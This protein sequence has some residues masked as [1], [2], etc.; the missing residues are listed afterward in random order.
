[1]HADALLSLGPCPE[2]RLAWGPVKLA[3][4]GRDPMLAY[5]DAIQDELPLVAAE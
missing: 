2:H 1:V 3:L 4:L 5:E